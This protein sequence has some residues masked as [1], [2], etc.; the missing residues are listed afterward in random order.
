MGKNTSISLGDH[1]EGFIA[2][3]V[4]TGR[5]GNRS[6]VIRAALREM[7]ERQRK[8]ATLELMERSLADIH[9]GRTR[10]AKQALRQIAADLGLSLDR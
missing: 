6:E 7:E 5:Y 2:S 1:F 9:A 10:P 8:A 3:Q 4:E